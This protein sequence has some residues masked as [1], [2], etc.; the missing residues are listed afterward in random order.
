[1]NRIPRCILWIL[2]GMMGF[3]PTVLNADSPLNPPQQGWEGT[4]PSTPRPD[5]WEPEGIYC[6]LYDAKTVVTLK[7]TVQRVEK[8]IPLKG[9]GRG[10][11]LM[12]KTGSETIPVQLGPVPYVE[13]QPVQI[14]AQD[15][16]EVTGSRVLCDGKPVILAAFITRG[17]ETVRFRTRGGIPAWTGQTP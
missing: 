5:G 10:Y 4:P 11:H 16:V 8:I 7:G 12:L 3:Y 9:M 14:H 13:K 6:R 1:M 2:L 15:I 17:D